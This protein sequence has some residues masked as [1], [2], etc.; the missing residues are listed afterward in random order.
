MSEYEQHMGKV[1]L[2]KTGADEEYFKS[3]AEQ[4]GEKKES[5]HESWE[6][7]V[8]DELYD[9]YVIVKDKVFKVTEREEL[10]GYGDIIHARKTGE[11]EYFFVLK[12]YNGG[13]CFSECMEAALKNAA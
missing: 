10:E 2:I 11:D 6:E 1:K 12:F 4:H 8:R 5:Y 3:L 13:T 9:D 7:V